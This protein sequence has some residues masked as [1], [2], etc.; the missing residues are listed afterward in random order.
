MEERA[1]SQLFRVYSHSVYNTFRSAYRRAGGWRGDL[2]PYID[3]R[4]FL[5]PSLNL[6]YDVQAA[7]GYINLVP[8]CLATLWGTEKQL[9]QMDAGL[10]KAED[11]LIAKRGFVKSLGLYN[12]RFL[13]TSEPAQDK[14][15]ELVGVY[16]PNAHL[17][18]NKETMPRAYAVP[19]YT[20]IS[21]T[22]ATLELI[23]RPSFDP[24]TTVVLSEQPEGPPLSRGM[25]GSQG[26]AF[27]A[28]VEVV[29][30]EPNRV[31]IDAKLSGPGWLVLSDTHYPGW[32]ATVDERSVPIYQANGCVRAV[33][34][35]TGRH[36]VTFSFRPRP[37]YIGASIT[38]VSGALW[39][40]IWLAIKVRER[41]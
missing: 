33:P 34:L 10:V 35:E 15:L 23:R 9:G 17:Y 2:G 32:E 5:Q 38:G 31:V 8:E 21:D 30:Y 25:V 4:E 3:Q 11:Q 14:E 16:G 41:R 1:G 39:V 24:E 36:K 37:F 13:I 40:A 19:D 28:T 20:V 12:V 7:D 27:A 22:L 6:I 29:V 26:E 18:E